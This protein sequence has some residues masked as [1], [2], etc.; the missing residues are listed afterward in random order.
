MKKFSFIIFALLLPLNAG[1]FAQSVGDL[2]Q[3]I[4]DT[5]KQRDALLE[6]RKQIQ[7][8]IQEAESKGQTL[9]STIK[10]LEASRRAIDNN[11][12][13]TN[14]SINAANLTIQKLTLTIGEKQDQIIDHE[15][16]ISQS[17][18]RL[19]TYDGTSLL[20]NFLTAQNLTNV[21]SDQAK[22]GSLEDTLQN[23]IS[24]LQSDQVELSKQK[25]QKEET[26]AELGSLKNELA[27]Q[28]Q[29]VES[30]KAAQAALL[31]QTKSKEAAYQKLLADNIAREKQFEDELFQYQSQLK[32]PTSAAPGAKHGLLVW[33]LGKILITQQFGKT[34][35]SGRLYASGTHSGTDFGTPV[36]SPVMSA[37]NGVVTGTGNTDDERSCYSYGR[38]VFIKYDNGLSSIYGHL[39]SIVV[40]NGQQVTAGQVVAYSGGIPGAYGSG[41]STGPHLHMGLFNSSG[42]TIQQYSTSIG[43]R[44]TSLPLAN[45]ADYLDPLAYLPSL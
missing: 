20:T 15:A 23:E 7:I 6:E 31:A 12:K 30:T 9:S 25:S 41:Y 21:W 22:L 27:G 44:N 36:G 8:Q 43:C 10:T 33:P 4:A 13:I 18:R 5:Q 11:L 1:L 38:W 34:A 35:F 2:E 16:A 17:L 37:G 29:T 28:K 24:A 19:S 32:G 45:P 39:S 40:Q 26:K 42:V 3:K 14:Q